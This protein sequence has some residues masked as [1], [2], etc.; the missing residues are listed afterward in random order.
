MCIPQNIA[1]HIFMKVK[2]VLINL[3]KVKNISQK[4][5]KQNNNI[6]KA[7]ERG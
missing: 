3:V 4:R 7:M 1:H 2:V 6:K 5:H